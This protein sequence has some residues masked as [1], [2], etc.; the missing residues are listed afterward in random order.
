[1]KENA[2][3]EEISKKTEEIIRV[4]VKI[5]QHTS[6]ATKKGRKDWANIFLFLTRG[7]ESV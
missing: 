4:L 5:F 2:N 6:G 7:D 3:R 1:M